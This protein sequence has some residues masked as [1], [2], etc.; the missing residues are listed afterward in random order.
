[1][2]GST[3]ST[4][5]GHLCP[6]TCGE[7]NLIR[8]SQTQDL[9]VTFKLGPGTQDFSRSAASP[10]PSSPFLCPNH[11]SYPRHFSQ[12]LVGGPC[13]CYFAHTVSLPGWL[14]P[15]HDLVI[16]IVLQNSA[17]AFH[18]NLHQRPAGCCSVP[19]ASSVHLYGS[20]SHS[21]TL[22]CH[23]PVSS[24]HCTL[25]EDRDSLNFAA[26]EHG[27]QDLLMCSMSS[28]NLCKNE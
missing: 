19:K 23:W 25:L 15:S 2:Q 24:L 1:M 13:P 26:T 21:A 4:H 27:A 20:T 16:L 7:H 10:A 14:F 5:P 3:S 8:H 17:Q 12:W 6:V 11:Q 9:L 28:V 18:R 22:R